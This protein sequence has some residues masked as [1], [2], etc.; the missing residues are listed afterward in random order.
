MSAGRTSEAEGA[1]G[2]VRHVPVLLPEVLEHLRVSAEGRFVDGTFGAGGYT[3][4]IL[5]QGGRVLAIDRDRTAIDAGQALVEQGAGKL[6][7][8]EGRFSDLDELAGAT[9]FAP[10]DGVVLDVG[11]SS[12]QLDQAERGFSFRFDGPLDMRMGQSGADAAAGREPRL[13]Q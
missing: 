8:V 5:E 12:M 9:G 11:V 4:G 2:P 6:K 7:L 10:A 3:R 13:R 1:G